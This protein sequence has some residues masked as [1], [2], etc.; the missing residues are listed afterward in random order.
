MTAV[1]ER[2][3]R[4]IRTYTDH[5]EDADYCRAVFALADVPTICAVLVAM[6]QSGDRSVVVDALHFMCDVVNYG[7][8]PEFTQRLPRSGILAPLRDLLYAPDQNVRHNAIHTLGKMGPRQNAGMLAE[9]FPHYLGHHPLELPDLLFELFWLSRKERGRRWD[10]Y[11]QMATSSLYLIRW[12]MLD[13]LD[14]YRSTDPSSPSSRRLKHLYEGLSTDANP[15]VAAEATYELAKRRELA[16][17]RLDLEAPMLALAE[18][19][20]RKKQIRLAEPRLTFMTLEVSFWNYLS[21]ADQADYDVA[22]LDAFAY[23]RLHH[24]M[25]ARTDR[26]EYARAFETWRRRKDATGSKPEDGES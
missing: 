22:T 20:R 23:F 1:E 17:L 2:A 9:A 5:L 14:H 6:F 15:C 10:Y 21:A 8:L 13:V 11:D 24:P 12:S 18:W 4:L 19:Q 7:M 26:A 3:E 16:K 25:N